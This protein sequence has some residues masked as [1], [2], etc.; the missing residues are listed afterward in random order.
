MGVDIAFWIIAVLAVG[1]AVSVVWARNLFRSALLLVLCFFAVAGIYATMGAD[2][3]AMA[4]ILVYVGAV[5]VLVIFAVMLTKQVQQG[6]QFNRAWPSAFVICAILLAGF[7][8]VFIDTNW[9]TVEPSSVEV[10][11]KIA[12]EEPTTSSIAG[13]LFSKDYGF[14]L[15]FEIG[16]ALILA[17]VIG[18]IAIVREK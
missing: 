5:A 9:A 8:F 4:Q 2:F 18:A 1:S 13:A 17:A 7:I 11:N 15:P 14:L 16:A 6:N 10:V 12:V 3:L